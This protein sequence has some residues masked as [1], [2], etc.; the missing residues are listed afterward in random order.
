LLDDSPSLAQR[1]AEAIGE[2]L[3]FARE[4]AR[5]DLSEFNEPLSAQ[6]DDLTFTEDQAIGP[7]LPD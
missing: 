7:W 1:V 3:G 2:E 5:S 4:L 6:I